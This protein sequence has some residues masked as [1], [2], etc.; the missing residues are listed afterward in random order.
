M[1]FCA[2]LLRYKSQKLSK[3]LFVN[4]DKLVDRK[5]LFQG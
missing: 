1:L 3:K 2:N 4:A 5:I